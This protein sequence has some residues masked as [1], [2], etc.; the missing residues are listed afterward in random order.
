MKK[1]YDPW[2]E[3]ADS[4]RRRLE[5]YCRRHDGDMTDYFADGSIYGET[6]DGELIVGFGVVGSANLL[7][8]ADCA[9]CGGYFSREFSPM[10]KKGLAEFRS[11]LENC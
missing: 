9:K 7:I 10:L 8:G 6:A 2:K 1:T 3:E 5:Q 4:L 11:L